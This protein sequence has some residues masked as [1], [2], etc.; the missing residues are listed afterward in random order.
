[1]KL[2]DTLTSIG[3]LAFGTCQSLS[4]IKIPDSVT[5]L[6]GGAFS[7]CTSLKT[8]NIPSRITSIREK[9]F[10]GDETPLSKF[11]EKI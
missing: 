3:V 10:Y 11:F 9:L 2:P 5:E 4:E 6:G 1:V 8:A 7:N